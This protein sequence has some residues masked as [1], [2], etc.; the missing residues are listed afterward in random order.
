MYIM[1]GCCVIVLLYEEITSSNIAC[2][3]KIGYYTEFHDPTLINIAEV[4]MASM[5]I[6]F[7]K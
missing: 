3:L 5:L 7:M 6:L 1:G 4:C 2:F